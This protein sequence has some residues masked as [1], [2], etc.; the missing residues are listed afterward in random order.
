METYFAT[1]FQQKKSTISSVARVEPD[2][3]QEHPTVT[4]PSTEELNK[5]SSQVTPE[6]TYSVD[7]FNSHNSKDEKKDEDWVDDWTEEPS[8]N[9]VMMGITFHYNFA[10]V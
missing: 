4:L 5:T 3:I 9:E 2:Y 1:F 10:P 7:T 6:S 8:K